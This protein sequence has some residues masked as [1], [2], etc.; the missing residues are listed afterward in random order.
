MHVQSSPCIAGIGGCTSGGSECMTSGSDGEPLPRTVCCPRLA[1]LLSERVCTSDSY[2]FLLYLMETGQFPQP[3]LCEASLCHD[4]Q[5]GNG[6]NGTGSGAL[7]RGGEDACDGFVSYSSASGSLS[8]KLDNS[9]G[10]ARHCSFLIMPEWFYSKQD[11]EPHKSYTAITVN[12]PNYD[13]T[14][15]IPPPT[16]LAVP[17]SSAAVTFM[18]MSGMQVCRGALVGAQWVLT[19]AQCCVKFDSSPSPVFGM[20]PGNNF[21]MKRYVF[22]ATH[23]SYFA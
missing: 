13:P 10:A 2:E 16:V 12:G 15:L 4:H 20:M 21:G 8:I 1:K 9:S 7:M 17:N 19:T 14:K 22:L 18:D 5:A 23:G 3:L 11:G 6:T